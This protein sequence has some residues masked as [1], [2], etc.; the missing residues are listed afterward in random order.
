MKFWAIFH[1]A[2]SG[3]T[4]S[5]HFRQP[6]VKRECLRGTRCRASARRFR[7][8]A[9][10]QF[11]DAESSINTNHLQ[12]VTHVCYIPWLMVDKETYKFKNGFGP[13]GKIPRVAKGVEVVSLNRGANG[14]WTA[15]LKVAAE[16]DMADGRV[17]AVERNVRIQGKQQ[18][19][20]PNPDPFGWKAKRKRKRN[21]K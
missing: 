18:G 7:L 11:I 2:I 9:V 20:R 5:S 6:G 21:S 14:R 8:F 19:K 17:I 10:C 3:R 1:R 12:D 16:F 15:V 4:L 13:A